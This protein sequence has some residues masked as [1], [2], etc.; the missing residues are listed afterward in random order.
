[1]P[2][3]VNLPDLDTVRARIAE[4]EAERL[5]VDADVVAE[6]ERKRAALHADEHGKLTKFLKLYHEPKKRGPRKPK[7]A[8]APY[9]PGV[10]PTPD[11]PVPEPTPLLDHLAD[12]EPETVTAAVADAGAVEHRRR[13]RAM[14]LAGRQGPRVGQLR[15]RRLRHRGILGGGGRDGRDRRSVS[16]QA[17]WDERVVKQR[18]NIAGP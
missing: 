2:T 16:F 11:P 15:L 12:T 10:S 8:P 17:N 1:M 7:P 4:I 14:A 18:L 13:S 6:I 9:L 3:Q 5:T